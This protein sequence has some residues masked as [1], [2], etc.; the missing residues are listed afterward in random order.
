MRSSIVTKSSQKKDCKKH[1]IHL[2]DSVRQP[3]SSLYTD[4]LMLHRA[5]GNHA[6]SQLLQ[7]GVS[8]SSFPGTPLQRKCDRG[9][10]A[11]VVENC[12]ECSQEQIRPSEVPLIVHRTLRAHGKPLEQNVRASMESRFDYDFRNV[13]VHYDSQAIQSA[14]AIGAKAYTVGQDIVFGAEQYR[15]E[16]DTGRGLL[17]HELTHVVQQAQGV[18]GSEQVLESQAEAQEGYGARLHSTAS[19]L[20]QYPYIVLQ[21]SPERITAIAVNLAS[22]T[23]TISVDDGTTISGSLVRVNLPEGSYQAR[24]DEPSG[25]LEI[26][27]LPTP[28]EVIYF[29]VSGTPSF[30][31]RYDRLRRLIT[32][33]IPFTVISQAPTA[34]TSTPPEPGTVSL[35]PDEALR[36]CEANDLPGIK[37]FPFRATRFGAAPIMA[38]REGNEIVVEQPQYVRANQ[39]FRAQ[40]R[41]LPTGRVRLSP[42]EIVRVH[43]YEPRWYHLNITGSTEGDIEHEFCVTGEQMRDIAAASTTATWVNIGITGVE[44]LTLFIPVGKVAT[45]AVQAARPGLAATMIGTAEVIAPRTLAAAGERAAVTIVEEQA[46]TQVVGR[47]VQRTVAQTVVQTAEPEV[48]QLA[49]RATSTAVPRLV[50]GGVVSATG[51][52]VLEAGV[53]TTGSAIRS[54]LTPTGGGGPTVAPP[55]PG[56]PVPPIPS[57]PVPGSPTSGVMLTTVTGDRIIVDSNIARSLDKAARGLPLQQGERLMVA[58]VQQQGI[59]ITD[60]TVAELAVRGG[61]QGTARVIQEVATTAAERQAIMSTLERAGVGGGVPDRQIVQQALL[62]QTAPGVVPTLATAD[63]GMINGLA[64]L[65]RI[66]PARLGR[67]RTVAE[68]LFYER[69]QA[70][71]FE[72]VIEGRRLIVMPIQAVRGG[73]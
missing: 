19:N 58:R 40:T 52:G 13:R 39:D 9:G 33:A 62:A 55:G 59:V 65:A 72:V 22:Q 67:Y 38:R 46:V 68:Y 66:D 60:R 15:P 32:E 12:A 29:E 21:M 48:A 17:A 7:P 45:A 30:L 4:I 1:E 2:Q 26:T 5:A 25:G 73:L 27:P 50:P 16:T 71:T 44:T 20:R 42:N 23:V 8:H 35:T 57:P 31:R 11:K 61:V 53:E 56:A 3:S 14:E 43:V 49:L 10:A 63:R 54:T 64:R 34:T 6:V 28:E 69:S 51:A 70:T 37:I 47:A 24:W 41:T 18:P 36:R